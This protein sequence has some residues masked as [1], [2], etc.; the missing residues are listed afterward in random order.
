MNILRNSEIT[1]TIAYEGY[2]ERQKLAAISVVAYDMASI[3]S[4]AIS[5]AYRD[6][7]RKLGENIPDRE[8]ATVFEMEKLVRVY[9]K[10]QQAAQKTVC[11]T[12][13][14]LYNEGKMDIY[15]RAI[16]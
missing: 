6:L 8:K 4:E 7:R 14:Y 1:E 12:H 2:D 15:G 9:E 3:A 5:Y 11:D 13:E 16:H 10:A